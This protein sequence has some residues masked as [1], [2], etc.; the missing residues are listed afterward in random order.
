[1]VDRTN[2]EFIATVRQQLAAAEARIQEMGTL[3]QKL[4]EMGGHDATEADKDNAFKLFTSWK[5]D[6]VKST[7]TL[8][9]LRERMAALNCEITKW[10]GSST[11]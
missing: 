11:G 2:A 7:P 5:V 3:R 9:G 6:K 4:Q 8:D 1:M 10:S